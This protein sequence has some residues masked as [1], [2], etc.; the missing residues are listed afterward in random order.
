M[1]PTLIMAKECVIR[2]KD[3]WLSEKL[4][5]IREVLKSCYSDKTK[6]NE[7]LN[8]IELL[9]KEKQELESYFLI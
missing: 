9:Q 6:T 7:L 5:E 1:N 2:L 3:R 8:K 4:N